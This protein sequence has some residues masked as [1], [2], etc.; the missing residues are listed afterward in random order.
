LYRFKC[1][2]AKWH[3][4]MAAIRDTIKH[5]PHRTPELPDPENANA[6]GGG[7]SGVAAGNEQEN[8]SPV[9][10]AQS[11][12]PCNTLP[13]SIYAKLRWLIL[14]TLSAT[15]ATKAEDPE[16]P[17]EDDNCGLPSQAQFAYQGR[18]P[19]GGGP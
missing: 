2:W 6:D 14:L 5:S 1:T 8:V 9:P 15:D 12:T 10:P 19:W 3:A 16:D 18:P 13:P 4:Q 17:E 7:G 11:L